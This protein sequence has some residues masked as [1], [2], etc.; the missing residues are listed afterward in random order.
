MLDRYQD[1]MY[2][3]DPL[4]FHTFAY[5]KCSE[6]GAWPFLCPPWGPPWGG[7]FLKW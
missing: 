6:K 4:L 5:L 3:T 2:G 7:S 1:G